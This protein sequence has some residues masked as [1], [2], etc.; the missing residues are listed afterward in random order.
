M[1]HL[2]IDV[3]I[4]TLSMIIIVTPVEARCMSV[5]PAVGR[6]RIVMIIFK[7]IARAGAR[8]RHYE[9]GCGGL[10]G[11]AL[12]GLWLLLSQH[13]SIATTTRKDT[14]KITCGKM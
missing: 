3:N 13:R 10:S 11:G 4:R 12:W 6:L 9:G 1:R 8:G 7:R 2:V 5:L 14:I